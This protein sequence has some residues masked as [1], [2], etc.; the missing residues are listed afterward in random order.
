MSPEGPKKQKQKASSSNSQPRKQTANKRPRVD[1]SHTA[2]QPSSPTVQPT[3]ATVTSISA[4]QLVQ[5]PPPPPHW[6]PSGPI[7]DQGA[8]FL[9]AISALAGSYSLSAASHC[10]SHTGSSAQQYGPG[11]TTDGNT[12][13]V[14]S[15]FGGFAG[16]QT[17]G[18]FSPGASPNTMPYYPRDALRTRSYYNGPLP[19]GSSGHLQSQYPP[20]HPAYYH[21]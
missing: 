12:G 20:P 3:D 5:P 15:G 16:A 19:N 6:K 4:T 17:F 13:H 10:I 11:Y 1:P 21:L 2:A 9:T 14:G 8:M 7:P 18:G